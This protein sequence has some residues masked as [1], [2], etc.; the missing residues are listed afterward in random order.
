[1]EDVT[2]DPGIQIYR[3]E[4][5]KTHFLKVS[6]HQYS[7]GTNYQTFYREF[8]SAI[9]GNLKKRGH[10]LQY[11][12]NRELESDETVSPTFEETIVLWCLEKIDPR[13]PTHVNK[14]F[15]HL[16]TGHTTLKDLQIQIFQHIGSMIQDLDDIEAN[17][18][19]TFRIFS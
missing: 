13:L 15:S 9:I 2:E 16:M 3:S 19:T 4:N 8:R 1:M 10:Q 6:E 5:P 18:A 14:T 17:R 11:Q 12:N 7:S